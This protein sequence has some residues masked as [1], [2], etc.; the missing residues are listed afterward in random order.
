MVDG[1]DMGAVVPGAE[2]SDPQSLGDVGRAVE[3][4]FASVV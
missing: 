1:G 4:M 2:A 3:N